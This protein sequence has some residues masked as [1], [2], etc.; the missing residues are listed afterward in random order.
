M[1]QKEQTVAVV[2]GASSGIG[3][4]TAKALAREG[5]RVV[6]VARRAE[7][8]EALAATIAESG[9][10]ARAEALDAADGP[11]VMAMA[12][13]VRAEWGAPSL[14]INNAGAGV[15]R[16]LEETSVE[17]IVEMM[18]APYLA[19]AN[20][21]RAFIED[22]LARRAG[23]FIHVCSPASVIPWPGATA[24]T[25][26]R[27]ALRGL[28]EALWQDL[29]GTGVRSSMVYFG[30]V[31]SEYFEVNAGSHRYMPKLGAP[32]PVST[33]EQCAEALLKVVRHP[34]R[35]VFY[36][37]ML[38]FMAWLA[39]LTPGPTRWLAARTGRRH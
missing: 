7:R 12:E 3:A 27:W 10:E 14:V 37:F 17:E 29:R 38:R 20:T 25:G 15:W 5:W 8:L 13:R 6:L 18:G 1:K 2:T 21:S 35:V 33:P 30:E 16:F 34:K 31:S 26:S 11:A 22:M 9:G 28:H 24:Y 32:I 4:A 39:A 19:A 23:H 36:P